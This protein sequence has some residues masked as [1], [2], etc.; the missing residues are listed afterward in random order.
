MT[1]D[2][3]KI[4]SLFTYP[5]KG[6]SAQAVTSAVLKNAAGFPGDR[7]WG[8]AKP[9]DAVDPLIPQSMVKNRFY[10]LLKHEKLAELQSHYD[11]ASQR[12]VLR[13][14]GKVVLDHSLSSSSAA[15][16]VTEFIGDFLNLSPHERPVLAHAG[17]HQFTDSAASSLEMRGAW[18]KDSV[19]LV[20]LE[21]VADLAS[22]SGRAVDPLRFRG[23]IYF[24]GFTPFA[25][26]DWL[27][28]EIR[29][30]TARLRVFERTVRCKATEV[31]PRTG[32]RDLPTVKLLQDH[33]GH[34]DMGIYAMVEEGGVI[35]PGDELV[36][37]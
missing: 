28:R 8:F 23:N 15:A 7:Q 24:T 9:G 29:I 6:F 2:L 12:L 30:G 16:V 20:G 25:E 37:V 22:K 31:D 10:V 18:R 27:G 13:H 32:L 14:H 34:A 36:L 11:A 3:T 1:S 35:K 26:L 33:Y 4:E 17:A 21:S 19:S 5:L